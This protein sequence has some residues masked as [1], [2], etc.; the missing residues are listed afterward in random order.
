MARAPGLH[1][2]PARGPHS[3]GAGHPLQ[4]AP[5][6]Q[7]LTCSGAPPPGP[8]H[9]RP[10]E[11]DWAPRV[12]RP[13]WRDPP[14]PRPLALAPCGGC[15]GEVAMP[16]GGLRL[17]VAFPGPGRFPAPCNSSSGA[18]QGPAG[19]PGHSARAL[20]RPS[21][22][23]A[24]VSVCTVSSGGSRQGAAA[25]VPERVPQR[26]TLCARLRSALRQRL[27]RAARPLPAS[28]SCSVL[29]PLSLACLSWPSTSAGLTRHWPGSRER[30]WGQVWAWQSQHC[31]R[32]Q[33]GPSP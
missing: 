14:P 5:V 18:G 25:R 19:L 12:Q 24:F 28:L 29:G 23:R 1:L 4:P 33:R 2:L 15:C 3:D 17:R 31:L 20:A 22:S 16:S 8:V 32:A 7:S 30:R 21:L 6:G 27:P 9:V 10:R 11:E 13:A 26:K